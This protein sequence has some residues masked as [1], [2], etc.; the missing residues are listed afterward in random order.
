[1]GGESE[2]EG[3]VEVCQNGVWSTVCDDQWD[4]N[5]AAVVCRQLGYSFDGKI[6]QGDEVD[7]LLLSPQYTVSALGNSTVQISNYG[8]EFYIGFMRNYLGNSDYL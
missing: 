8:K 7:W 1:M 5:D 6:Y 2:R 4:V 3:T